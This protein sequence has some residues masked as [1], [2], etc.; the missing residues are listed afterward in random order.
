MKNAFQ[1]LEKSVQLLS[2]P[3]AVSVLDQLKAEGVNLDARVEA[4]RKDLRSFLG[5]SP[6]APVSLAEALGESGFVPATIR[7][8][9][10]LQAIDRGLLQGLGGRGERYEAALRAIS[11]SV[12]DQAELQ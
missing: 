4:S 5:W 2:I 3:L 8:H 7:E 9:A 11:E 1:G 6:D 12:A 10:L